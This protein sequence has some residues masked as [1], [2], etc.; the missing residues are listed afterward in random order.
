M[1]D[2]ADGQEISSPSATGGGGTFFEQHVGAYWLALVLV[3]GCPPIY[4]DTVVR[5]VSFQAE[6]LGWHTDDILITCEAPNAARRRIA[7]QVKK[8]FS[9]GAED[10]DFRSAIVD[11]WQD[12]CGT[13]FT[14][15]DAFAFVT[16]RGTNVILRDLATLLDTSRA[17]SDAADFAHRLETAAFVSAQVRRH[18]RVIE[19]ILDAHEEAF[20]HR[21]RIWR[22]VRHIYVL[23]FDLNTDTAQTEA[24]M[25]T[26]LARTVTSGEPLASAIVTWNELLREASSGIPAARAYERAD[27]PP[28]AVERH[29]VT[30]PSD[31]RALA[32]LSHHTGVILAG[33]QTKIG[34]VVHLS[35]AAVA[36]DVLAHL[37]RSRVLLLTGNAGSGKSGIAKEIAAVLARDEFVFAFRAEEFAQS[38]LDSALNAV[39]LGITA[40]D[41]AAVVGAQPRKLLI[42]ESVERILEAA[43]R[44]A[45]ADLLRFIREDPTWRLIITCR[46]YSVNLLRVAFLDASG[47]PHATFGVPPLSDDE[48]TSVANEL[49]IVARL[50]ANGRMKTLL[51]NAYVL[52]MAVRIPWSEHEALPE[53]ERDFRRRFWNQFVRAEDRRDGGMPQRRAEAFTEICVRR[54][55]ALTLFARVAGLDAEAVAALEH[56]SLVVFSAEGRNAAAP[57]HDVLEDWGVF[58]WIDETYARL[59]GDPVKFSEALGGA[60]AIRRTYRA[61][62][63]EFL[64]RDGNNADSLFTAVVSATDI[65][66]Y[67]RDDTIIAFLRSPRAPELL[68]RHAEKILADE[69]RLFWRIVH[70]LRVGCV[71][72]PAWAPAMVAASAFFQPEG[73]AWES[74][75]RLTQEHLQLFDGRD[76]QQL[77][78]FVEDWAKGVSYQTS[79]PEGHAAAAAITLW[80]IPY[81]SDYDSEK[82]LKRALSVLAKIPASDPAGFERVLHGRDDGRRDPAA[83]KLAEL[84]FDG[85]E[86]Y[87]AARDLPQLVIS[88]AKDYFLIEEED[89]DDPYHSPIDIDHFFGM[90]RSHGSHLPP[91]AYRGPFRALLREHPKDGRDLVVELLNYAGNWYGERRSRGQRLE[92]A[93][94]IELTF[95]DGTKKTQWANPRLWDLYRG[96]SVTP[97]PLQ[98]AAMALEAWLFEVAEQDFNLL[99]PLL[100]QTL[101]MADSVAV[102]AIVASLA[103]RYPGACGETLLVFLSNPDCIRMDRMRMVQDQTG[104]VYPRLPQH[105]TLNEIFAK[106]RA[107]SDALPHR[108][109]DLEMAITLLQA[110]PSAPRVHD[111]LDAHVA[112]LPP[113]DVQTEDDQVWRFALHRMDLRKYRVASAEEVLEGIAPEGAVADNYVILTPQDPDPDLKAVM[114]QSAAE[115]SRVS[116]RLGDQMWGVKVFERETDDKYDPAEWRARLSLVRSAPQPEGVREELFFGDAPTIIAAV[117]VRDH[118]DDLTADERTW[119]AER[120]FAA[121]RASGR[122]WRDVPRMP[123]VMGG[124]MPAA[125]VAPLLVEYLGGAP[126]PLKAFAAAL[127]HPQTEVRVAA[128]RAAGDVLWRQHPDVSIRAMKALRV[129]AAALDDAFGFGGNRRYLQPEEVGRVRADSADAARAIICSDTPASDSATTVTASNGWY[130]AEA[131]LGIT[132]IALGAPNEAASVTVFSEVATTLRAWWHA[133][134]HDRADRRES[135][136]HETEYALQ[137][138]LAEALFRVSDA[139]AT[140]IVAPLRAAVEKHPEKVGSVFED[141]TFREDR[142]PATERYWALWEMFA[143]QAANASWL[144]DVDSKYSE[145]KQFLTAVFLSSNW[146]E[147]T[148]HWKSV[149][150]HADEI[151]GLFERLPLSR[152]SLHRYLHFLYHV[153][154]E[155]LPQAFVRLHDKL[156]NANV[157]ELLTERDSSFVLESLLLRYVYAKPLELKR[158]HDLREAVLF[159]LDALV[160]T[161]SSSAF[162][163]RD[164]FVTPLSAATTS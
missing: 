45:F 1:T 103:V 49:P 111:A 7:C 32:R 5:R 25:R 138:A 125:Q 131:L 161:G 12:F 121:V 41:F 118:W 3:E 72:L 142:D 119:C 91:S 30:A 42:V 130:A 29:S 88:A 113:I 128:A 23:A 20:V 81:C 135:R 11:A 83:K 95:A 57:A 152:T 156:R 99:D 117:C 19:E 75:L 137:K 123:G 145:G 129:E 147:A 82:L 158:Q 109:R 153:G 24:Q 120:V 33:I 87:A 92:E 74:I 80:L 63:A 56:D 76:R 112:A 43:T 108:R 122:D 85:I 21:D 47:V 35:R 93:R 102:T 78:S 68:R 90:N 159:L 105:E 143:A 70:L 48:L 9:V 27:L 2:T 133:D 67:F 151:H 66:H 54:A 89:L 97:Y 160:E 17:S 107:D 114:Q 110:G 10:A 116:S 69:K 79:P 52:D 50:V 101:R 132:S 104:S 163:M 100:L 26:I 127:T 94:E 157:A 61:W 4:I 86:G 73:A 38:H 134:R 115:Y 18:A 149:T 64:D 16:L 162:R 150:G 8:S 164:D 62:V 44:D 71:K 36:T 51:R 136:S 58:E 59:A 141:L 106:E 28:A 144:P 124:T 34:G 31:R 65:H 37:E 60:P 14:D 55:K 155:S 15:D 46:D 98:S 146:K 53:T 39:G 126:E 154:E 13:T 6:H 84:V 40:E 139:N 22:F 96:T 140:T 77:L 148:R